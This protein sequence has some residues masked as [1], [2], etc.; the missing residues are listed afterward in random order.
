MQVISMKL[1]TIS[2]EFYQWEEE[3]RPVIIICPGGGYTHHSKREAEPVA[4]QYVSQGYNVAIVYYSINKEASMPRPIEDLA[5]VVKFLKSNHEEYKVDVDKD[6]ICGFSAGGHVAAGLAVFWN[7][8]KVLGK[9]PQNNALIRPA[10]II[11]CYPLID[12]TK[13]T[14][15]FDGDLE[16]SLQSK[17]YSL[18]NQVSK[19]TPPVFI[20]HGGKDTSIPYLNSIKFANKLI[21][22]NISLE[23]HIFSTGGHG[24]SLANELTARDENDIDS[25]CQEWFNLSVK[26]LKSFK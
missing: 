20:W 21:E 16:K 22:N 19:D 17:Y 3:E 26:W 13:F 10:G 23:L 15:C 5:E 18:Q 14:N 7:N 11:L 2:F 1:K 4:L 12:I 6:F 24:I 25:S 9:Y 8:A